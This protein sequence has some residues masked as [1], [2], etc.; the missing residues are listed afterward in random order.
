[1]HYF[2][3]FVIAAKYFKVFSF[4]CKNLNSY[5]HFPLGIISVKNVFWESVA[6]MATRNSNGIITYWSK[7]HLI[8]PMKD[9]KENTI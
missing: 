4:Q 5:N 3:E 1:M 2:L 9:I 8:N 6:S 7:M